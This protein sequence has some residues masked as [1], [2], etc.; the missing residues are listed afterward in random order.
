VET[1]E[2]IRRTSEIEEVTNLYL[3]HPLANRLTPIL[4]RLG[5]SPNAV[6]MAGMAFGGLAGVAYYHYRDPRWAVAGFVLMIAWHVMDGADGQLA[7]LTNAQ[8]ELGK[9]LDGI[10]DNVTFIAV[11]SG[12]AAA[13][14]RETGSWIWAL[15]IAAGLCH[16]VQSAAYEAQRQEYEFW[17]WDRKSAEL[18]PLDA[19]P[20][21]KAGG[22]IVPRLMD[23]IY[24]LFLRVQLQ[25]SGTV[26]EFHERMAA[27]LAAEPER[28]GFFRER[29]R[30]VFAPSVRRWSVMSANYRTLG[31][32]I[33]ALIGR[34]Q[35]YFWFEIVG[36]N[37][38]L[39]LL[40][41]RQRARYAAFFEASDDRPAGEI[42][43]KRHQQ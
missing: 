18:L 23:M 40:I 2:P 39:V 42:I 19:R 10:C 24:R 34:P 4:A 29:Y 16:A 32:F 37:L 25:V 1:S 30:V 22:P 17:G 26:M 21:R 20:T 5:I 43:G 38:I 33:A 13:L 6:S 12:L 9:I 14:S 35:Y 28:A 27:T 7:R 41:S 8:S 3:I 15:A 36:F 11:Y 31:I